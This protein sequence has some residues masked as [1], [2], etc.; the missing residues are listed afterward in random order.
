MNLQVGQEVKSGDTAVMISNNTTMLVDITVDDR[1]ISFI[2]QGM[3]VELT[4]YNQNVFMGTVTSINMGGA[5]SKNG[6]TTYPVTLGGGQLRRHP[7]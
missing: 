7:V 5:E 1:N 6:M 2:N 4:D 3:T